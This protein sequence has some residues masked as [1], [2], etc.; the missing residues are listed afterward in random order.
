MKVACTVIF[1]SRDDERLKLILFLRESVLKTKRRL[2]NYLR[3]LLSELRQTHKI[4][5]EKDWYKIRIKP[6]Q[7][8][9]QT[10]FNNSFPQWIL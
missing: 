6:R 3:K 4:E 2:V 7:I 1:K 5:T 9:N 10:E 8:L